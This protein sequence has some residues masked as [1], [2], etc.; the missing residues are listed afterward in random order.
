MEPAIIVHGG[1]VKFSGEKVGRALEGTKN[2]ASRGYRILIQG[3][4]AIDAV[5]AAICELENDPTFDAGTHLYI[6]FLDILQLT[7][8]EGYLFID[9]LFARRFS[10][11]LLY[12]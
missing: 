8:P 10:K 6:H 12:C 11:K 5:Q 2:A 9:H 4:S 1:A 7:L 3:R